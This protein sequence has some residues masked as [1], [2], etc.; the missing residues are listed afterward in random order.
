MSVR[1]DHRH[2]LRALPED[3]WDAWLIERS[4]LP[5]PR[6]NLELLGAVV[7][8]ADASRILRYAELGSG[9]A[10]DQDPVTFLACCGVAGLGRLI[11]DGRGDLLATL[12]D[13]AS[14]PR[15][16]VREAV[17]MALQAIGDADLPR[18]LAIADDWADG[19]RL[20]QRAAVAGVCE[21]RLL[22]AEPVVVRVLALLD[23][24]TSS[25]RAAPDRRSDGFVA[26]RK[27]LGYGWSVAVA[28]APDP[29]RPAM[30]HWLTDRDPDVR[31]VM[32]QNLGKQRL[33]RV[34][35]GWVEEALRTLGP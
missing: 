34:D 29:G 25:V 10:G 30:G 21:P 20:E 18:L 19:G 3:G 7:D 1:E 2:A 28:A 4:G 8:A 5:G 32:R 16:R 26:L 14:D 13:H 31:W 12:R 6:A 33:V 27:A 11:I 35:A 22:R 15:W 9:S 24:V 23:R 17:A